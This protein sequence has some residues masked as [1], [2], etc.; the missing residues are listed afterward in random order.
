MRIDIITLFPE[1]CESVMSESIIGRARKKGIIE[2]VC[3]QLRDYALDK[4]KK[5]VSVSDSTFSAKYVSD[6][7]F[8]SNDFALNTLLTLLPAHLEIHLVNEEEDEFVQTLE[9]IFEGRVAICRN[10]HL[11]RLYK[12]TIIP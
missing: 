5:V 1:M 8:S 2:V 9:L 7:S 11:C 10:C 4:H 3:H 12:Q 6:I